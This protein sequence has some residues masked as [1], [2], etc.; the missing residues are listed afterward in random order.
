[1]ADSYKE[2]KLVAD[3]GTHFVVQKPSGENFKVAKMGLDP[4]TIQKISKL[5][6][7]AGGQVKGYSGES[8]DPNDSVVTPEP[9]VHGNYSVDPTA[10]AAAAAQPSLLDD[11]GKVAA[12]FQDSLR[13]DK[14]LPPMSQSGSVQPPQSVPDGPPS[15]VAPA[16]A[17]T[18]K[19]IVPPEKQMSAP[20][21][22]AMNSGQPPVGGDYASQLKQIY[23]L[24]SRGIVDEAKAEQM[25]GTALSKANLDAASAQQSL[26]DDSKAKTDKIV[27]NMT[28]L[29]KSIQDNP[30]NANRYWQNPDG[31]TNTGK[32][33]LS[34]LAIALGGAG[35]AFNGGHNVALDNINRQIDNDINQQKDNLGTKKSLLSQNL[36]TYKTMSEA[37]AHTRSQLEAIAQGQIGSANANALGPVAQAQK[38]QLLGGLKNQMLS[39]AMELGRFQSQMNLTRGSGSEQDLAVAPADIQAR[40]VRIPAP[41]ALGGQKIALASTPK[42]AEE[43]RDKIAK[44]QSIFSGLDRLE[45]LG[46]AAAVPGTKEN[47]MAKSIIPA[48]QFQL[49]HDQD[50]QRLNPNLLTMFSDQFGDPTK[51]T[52]FIGIDPKTKSSAFR[53]TIEDSLMGDY[54]SKLMNYKAPYQNPKVK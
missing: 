47:Q 24:Q 31:S 20:A 50:I 17:D 2:N 48:M 18:P 44:K 35:A 42:D 1:M 21:A 22:G 43:I 40:A 16:S 19:Q 34:F 51:W 23:D 14:G 9:E 49:A 6:M 29:T 4:L 30:I 52:R 28:D 27:Q 53:Q 3:N 5:K 10:V 46:P 41:N 15:P 13:A 36:D 32:K 12:N 54:K 26:L 25:K 7:C 37:M 11:A 8:G 45:Q 39:R 38:E 33:I